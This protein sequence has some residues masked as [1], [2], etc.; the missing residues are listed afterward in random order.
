MAKFGVGDFIQVIENGN[1]G[2]IVETSI[3]FGNNTSDTIYSVEW[4][5]LPGRHTYSATDAD[6]IW[7]KVNSVNLRLPRGIDFIPISIN[8]DSSGLQ[9][10]DN[11]LRKKECVHKKVDAGFTHSRIVCYHCGIDMI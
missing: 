11:T 5:F 4:E 2:L 9:A 8:L 7:E 1:K 6:L 10:S 3:F